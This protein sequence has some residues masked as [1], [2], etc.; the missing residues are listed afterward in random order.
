MALDLLISY[1][2]LGRVAAMMNV[3]LGFAVGAVMHEAGHDI[4]ACL[5]FGAAI[6]MLAG[7]YRV[8]S[9]VL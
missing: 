5:Y 9:E 3:L 8:I 6:A 1:C 2:Y 4:F 7:I